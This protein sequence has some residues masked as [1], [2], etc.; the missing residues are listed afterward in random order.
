MRRIFLWIQLVAAALVAIGVWLQVYFIASYFFG[1]EDAL[2]LHQNVGGAVH[3][4]EVLVFLL[5]FGA[6][7]RNWGRIG[8]AFGLGVI[9]TVQI[10]FS[11]SD[12]WVGGFHGLLALAVLTMAVF[13]VK[14]NA[15]EL[16]L[17]RGRGDAAAE[18]APP[19]PLP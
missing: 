17:T 18:T 6:W 19:R 3:A 4:V 16:G 9:G 15:D 13:I 10:A 8:H 11:E 7:W 14:W 1:A 5:A 12:E 2:D